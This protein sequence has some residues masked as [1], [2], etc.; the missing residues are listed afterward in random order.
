MEKGEEKKSI[1]YYEDVSEINGNAFENDS[2]HYI[3]Q[4]IYT[5][6]KNKDFSI[7]YNIEPNIE[8]INSIFKG[9]NKLYT[10]DK[11]QL[12]FIILNL[13]IADL[14]EFLIENYSGIHS[15]IYDEI[16]LSKKFVKN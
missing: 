13:K 7:I 5:I 4:K 9:N 3:L 12:D 8:K 16:Y 2:I 14:I 11:I 15:T 10:L 6:A 1:S